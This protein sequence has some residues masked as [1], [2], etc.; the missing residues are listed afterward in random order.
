MPPK[1]AYKSS[2]PSVKPRQET[3]INRCDLANTIMNRYGSVKE[4]PEA[5]KDWVTDLRAA[6]RG[7][8]SDKI[9]SAKDM[10]LADLLKNMTMES[11]DSSR[12]YGGN[13][14]SHLLA[15]NSWLSDAAGQ[16][17]QCAVYLLSKIWRI[18][19][20]GTVG[21]SKVAIDLGHTAIGNTDTETFKFAASALAIVTDSATDHMVVL[22]KNIDDYLISQKGQISK[23]GNNISADSFDK[24]IKNTPLS[25]KV[26]S[27]LTT[28]SLLQMPG[29]IVSGSALVAKAG[30]YGVMLAYYVSNSYV[31]SFALL[32]HAGFYQLRNDHQKKAIAFM[33]TVDELVAS[34]IP[35]PEAYIHLDTMM[36]E[37]KQLPDGI[38]K[39]ALEILKLEQGL[40][41]GVLTRTEGAQ[42]LNH[43]QIKIKLLEQQKNL[44]VEINEIKEEVRVLA[45]AS[46]SSASA[47]GAF[48]AKMDSSLGGKRKGRATRRH[49][50]SRR[51]TK[52]K[53]V[54]KTKRGTKTRR[55]LFGTN[56]K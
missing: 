32:T 22:T 18:L 29:L 20:V 19:S 26:Y 34:N 5:L 49:T 36:N 53:R 54:T 10:D 35:M 21:L 15:L 8:K 41:L 51:G 50:K 55:G 7:C 27:I 24:W 43:E 44:Q 16:L 33:K 31:F 37:L 2:A 38:K 4:D 23:L 6:Y 9:C 47:A 17:S 13:P 48:G 3:I 40:T 11:S 28:L 56:S 52:T 30:M 45:S 46:A 14:F 1:K 39:D 42:K 12:K 25:V